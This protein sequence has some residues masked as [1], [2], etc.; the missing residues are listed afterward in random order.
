[1][2]FSI[3]RQIVFR[4]GFWSQMFAQYVEINF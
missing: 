2:I 3:I 1:M 4:P